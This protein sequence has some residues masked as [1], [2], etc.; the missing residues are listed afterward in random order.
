[1]SPLR[2]S[3]SKVTLK[4]TCVLTPPPHSYNIYDPFMS[5]SSVAADL[6]V[7]EAAAAEK[8]IIPLA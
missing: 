2:G 3:A 5:L 7:Y 4:V 1:M 8:A 6:G